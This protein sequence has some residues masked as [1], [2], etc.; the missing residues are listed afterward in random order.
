[1]STK[2]AYI[3]KKRIY[4]QKNILGKR[5][6]TNDLLIFLKLVDFHSTGKFVTE[7]DA[8]SDLNCHF[9]KKLKKTI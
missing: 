1:M 7:K 6:N 4:K 3:N 8:T 5:T 2:N 9:V